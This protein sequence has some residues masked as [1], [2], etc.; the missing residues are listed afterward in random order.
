MVTLRVDKVYDEFH[1]ID[2]ITRGHFQRRVRK[3]WFAYKERKAEKARLKAEAAAAK[4]PRFGRR[5]TKAAP[6]PAA[7]PTPAAKPEPA[8][9]MPAKAPPVAGRRATIVG[10][11]KEL[12]ATTKTPALSK[13]LAPGTDLKADNV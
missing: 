4:K 11:P 2:V 6:K 13:T 9:T 5:T 7:A 1:R 10:I 8:A 3:V 12:A